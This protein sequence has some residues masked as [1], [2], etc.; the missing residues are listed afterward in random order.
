MT[1]KEA[2]QKASSMKL[3]THNAQLEDVNNAIKSNVD[4]GEFRL[5]YYKT[6]S[7]VVINELKQRGFSV[8]EFSDFRDGNNFVISW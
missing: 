1:A 5:N 3:S 7:E 2:R 8:Q 4:M 6:L